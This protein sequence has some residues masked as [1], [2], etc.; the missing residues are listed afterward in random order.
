MW[1]IDIKASD[2][3]L[4]KKAT[5]KDDY[6]QT[7]PLTDERL[8][9]ILRWMSVDDAHATPV[10]ASLWLPGKVV[11]P[12]T[13]VG[14][15]ADDPNDLY[16][17][18]DR[19][20]LRGFQVVCA[21]LNNIDTQEQNTL[22]TYVGEPGKGHLLHYQQDVGGTFGSRAAG[23]TDYFMGSERY[24]QSSRILFSFLTFGIFPRT[25][26]GED[27]LHERAEQMARWPEL[28]YFEAARFDPRG[29]RTMVYNPAFDL[30]TDR[31]HYWGAKRVVAVSEREL[32]A[33]ISS[34]Q[35][36]PEVAERLFRVLW[37]RREKIARAYLP[38]VAALDHFRVE[39]GRLC[40]DDIWEQANLGG[41]SR[42]RV[43]GG[44]LDGKCVSL[45]S[46]RGYRVVKLRV[47]R[48]GERDFGPRVNVHL[49]NTN[50]V[51]VER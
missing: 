30:A 26:E 41:G 2:L 31:D 6:H 5:T 13:Y 37:A 33:A 43:D 50:V 39:S 20:D 9:Q 34:G 15:R 29:W 1:L 45:P 27:V 51:G 48:P 22:D 49:N 42:Y 44:I 16:P 47:Q 3:I 10:V 7:V 36:R 23:P 11:G 40:F 24:F 19:R 4:D 32:R 17:H 25:W 18:Q 8:Q 12:Y 14:R 38:E 28:G 21:W 46:Q 35:Y